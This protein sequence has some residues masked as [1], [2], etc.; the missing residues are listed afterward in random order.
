MTVAS[1]RVPAKSRAS[2]VRSDRSIVRDLVPDAPDGGN[3]ARIAELATQLSHMNVDR[4]R[5]ARERVSP[6]PLEQLVSCQHEA[7]VV[8]QLP[9]QV[10]LLR[11]ELNVLAGN[12]HLTRARVDLEVTVLHHRFGRPAALGGRRGAAQD[13]LDPRDKL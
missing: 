2:L 7:P 5:V 6:P 9:Q 13:G 10:E 3:R 4:P 8:E 11:G 12:G 1:S